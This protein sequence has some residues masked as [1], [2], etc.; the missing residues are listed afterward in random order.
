M[1]IK[2]RYLGISVLVLSILGGVTANSANAFEYWGHGGR[3]VHDRHNG[4]LGWWWIVGPSWYFYPRPYAVTTPQTVIIQQP[5]QQQPQQ[6]VIEQ[7][8]PQAAVPSPVLYY[9][10]STETYYPDTMT[11]PGGWSTQTAGEPPK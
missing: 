5:V 4:R 3:W 6:V 8:A 10:R 7:G 2:A 9:C 11:C 1:T